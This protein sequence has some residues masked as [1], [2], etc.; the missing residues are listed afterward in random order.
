M[1]LTGE[2]GSVLSRMVSESSLFSKQ[3]CID[4]CMTFMFAGHD[5]TANT[6]AWY[7]PSLLHARVLTPV[8]RVFYYLH[9]NDEVLQK[10]HQEA[11]QLLGVN[12]DKLDVSAEKLHQMRYLRAVIMETLRRSP[13]ILLLERIPESYTSEN[14]KPG[15]VYGKSSALADLIANI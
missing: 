10:V 8:N 15:A 5:T 7:D 12:V 2:D 13:P 4:H 11:N 6:L 9:K 3:D 1:C 14:I